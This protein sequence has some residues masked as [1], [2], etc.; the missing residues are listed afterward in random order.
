[1]SVRATLA[2]S[3]V[4]S[5]NL[6]GGTV[7][8]ESSS[9]AGAGT[10]RFGR[11]AVAVGAGVLRRDRSIEWVAIGSAFAEVVVAETV[12]EAAFVELGRRRCRVRCC[13]RS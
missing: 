10:L 4:R 3:A 8:R 2:C 6:Q 1:M 13:F 11:M 12:A 7:Y 9:R 5:R